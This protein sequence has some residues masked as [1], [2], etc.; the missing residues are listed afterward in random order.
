MGL[1]S[2]IKGYFSAEEIPPEAAVERASGT[3]IQFLSIQMTLTCETDSK[4]AERIRAKFA[5]GY[6]LGVSDAASQAFSVTDDAELLAIPTLVF[7]HFFGQQD[8]ADLISQ[9]LRDQSDPEQLRGQTAGGSDLFQVLRSGGSRPA[10][11]L[12]RFLLGEDP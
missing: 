10:M 1:W 3:A 12:A 5:R 2:A 6:L 11:T 4:Y 7:V 9:S 8:G